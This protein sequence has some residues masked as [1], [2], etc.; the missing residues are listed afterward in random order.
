MNVLRQILRKIIECFL[1]VLV[2][3]KTWRVRPIVIGVTGSIGKTS[4]KEAIAA[5]LA[6]KHKVYRPQKSYNTEIGLLLGILEQ[7]SGFS[8]PI[9]W[10]KIM[11]RALWNSF[12]GK[13]YAFWVLE[14]GADKPGDIQHLIKIV[15]PNVG[16]ITKIA[17]VH[18]APGQFMNIDAIFA[19]KKYLVTCL[20]KDELAILNYNDKHLKT[21]EG[22]TKASILWFNRENQ[23][24]ASEL[25]ND[26][27]GFS[28]KIHF[29][30]ET[31]H[32]H[33]PILG[34]FHID[35]FLP[36]LLIGSKFGISL[37]QGIE[38]LQTFQLPPSRLSRIEGIN[39]SILLDSSYNASPTTV[40]AALE[41][42]KELPAKR[43]IAVLG[44]MNELGAYSIKAH[45]EIG[46]LLGPWIGLLI[47]VGEYASHIAEE[48]LN[49]GL[50][51]S[52]IVALS[53]AQE[54]GEFLQTFLQKGD[55]TLFKG[56]QNKVRL[57]IAIKLVMQHPARAKKLLCRQEEEWKKIS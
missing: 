40:K 23:I 45:S 50:P 49:Q 29:E 17:Q 24:E 28:A 35:I 18:Q 27:D 39:G 4:T 33:F 11:S 48:A 9:K 2:K 31:T 42:L 37:T 44:N 21:L 47:T 52:R 34:A 15:R 1:I 26:L 30:R 22:K 3:I 36:A 12:F 6:K 57:E 32:A 51:E 14:Y 43:R 41:L 19:E 25:K 7:E 20:C 54:A 16:V 46:K 55:M 8:S 53:S 5:V 10:I 38:A 13:K 56:S